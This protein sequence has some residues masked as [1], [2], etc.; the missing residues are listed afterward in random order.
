MSKKKIGIVSL[1]LLITIF[2]FGCDSDMIVTNIE[3]G[4][5]PRLVYIAGVDTELDFSEAT[6]FQTERNGR[7]LEE[8]YPGQLF[9]WTANDVQYWWRIQ[10]SIDF[11]RPGIYKVEMRRLLPYIRR[12][13]PGYPYVYIYFF[14]QVIDEEIFNK[15]K[16]GIE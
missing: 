13:D 14:I 5:P 11:N 4:T 10:H 2:L 6:F 3:L 15:L 1:L 9:S 12:R 8:P 7:R 16:F